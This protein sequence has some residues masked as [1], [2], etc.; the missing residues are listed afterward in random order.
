MNRL[1]L[2]GVVWIVA[3]VLAIVVATA[4]RFEMMNAPPWGAIAIVAGV[5]VAILGL[6]LVWRTD[7]A[8][9]RWSNIAGV[10]WVVL[11]AA[12][13][14]QQAGEVAAW[15][16]DVALAVIGGLAALIANRG[17]RTAGEGR[18]APVVI[19]LASSR[20]RWHSRCPSG[21]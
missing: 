7:A 9:V 5:V 4:Y 20:A 10:V 11:Y 17:A 21:R 6:A 12:L 13:A 3:A 8:L 16:T 2:A 15:G 14:L 1:R 19:R 18:D